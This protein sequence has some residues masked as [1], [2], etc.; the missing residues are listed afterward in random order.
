MG[1][2]WRKM[3]RERRVREEKGL[4]HSRRGYDRKREGGTEGKQLRKFTKGGKR[5]E[6]QHARLWDR[7]RGAEREHQG[8]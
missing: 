3:R 8:Q 1:E 5:R 6:T 4:E 2:G 7:E